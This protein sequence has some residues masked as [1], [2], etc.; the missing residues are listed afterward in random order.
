LGKAN[1]EAAKTRSRNLIRWLATPC[2][3]SPVARFAA[4][5]R[6]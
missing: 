1:N 3:H 5:L 2:F 4:I 6:G